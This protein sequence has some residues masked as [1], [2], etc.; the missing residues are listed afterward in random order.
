VTVMFRGREMVHRERGR[1]QLD[2]VA[3]LLTPIAK[4]ENPPRMEGRFMSMILV[5][6]REAVAEAKRIEEAQA[7]LEAKNAEVEDDGSAAAVPGKTG[8]TTGGEPDQALA[9]E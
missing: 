3:G 6:D 2:K 1:D 9:E 7:M 4:L 5:A 8:E